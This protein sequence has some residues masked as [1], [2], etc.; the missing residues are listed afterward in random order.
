MASEPV[1]RRDVVHAYQGSSF[2]SVQSLF[3]TV[4][5]YEQQSYKKKIVKCMSTK[6][7]WACSDCLGM[8]N[9]PVEYTLFIL[10]RERL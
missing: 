4:K 10:S 2:P 5:F 1:E 9:P 8:E 7:T 6:F 3:K